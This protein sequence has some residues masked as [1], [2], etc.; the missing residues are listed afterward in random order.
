MPD[1]QNC[2]AV[3]VFTVLYSEKLVSTDNLTSVAVINRVTGCKVQLTFI[4]IFM[5]AEDKM[6]N[7]CLQ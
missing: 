3:S 1:F 5:I 6:T 4:G 2:S 7:S